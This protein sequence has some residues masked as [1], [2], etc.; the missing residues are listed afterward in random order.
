MR[1]AIGVVFVKELRDALRD[2]RTAL[3]IL[4]ASIITGPLT[5]VLLAQFVAGLEE[6]AAVLKVRMAGEE[7][8]PQL[9]NFL[10]RN[11]IDIEAAPADYEARVRE[12]RMDAVIVVP[13][14]FDERMLAGDSATVE[15][16]Y[17][18]SR[19]E[20]GPAIRQAERLLRAFSRE[21][22]TLRMVARGV[23][24]DLAEPVKVE[25]VNTATPRQKGALVLFLIPMFAILAPLLG[26]MTVAID[27]TAGERER[28]SLE[29][30]LAN[31]VRASRFAAGKWLAAWTLASVVAALTLSGFVVAALAYAQRKL[32]A[33]AAFGAFEL[34]QFFA[35]IV[36]FAAMTSALQLLICT[37]GRTYRE[38]Q[39][40]SSYVFTVVSFVPMIVLFSGLKDAFWQ[41]MVPVLGQQMVLARVMR[42]DALG[43]A[44]YLVPAAIAAAIAAACLAAVS[45][46]L[47][48]ERI[49]FGR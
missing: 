8:A 9:V 5:L 31:P 21:T 47:R 23:S 4:V 2:R 19:T 34:L 30:L 7:H 36:P 32:E 20:A 14:D 39:T 49:V 37:Y 17:D 22:G 28:G 46:L 18:D 10:R 41:L 48:Q 27:S 40:Y 35:M 24:P 33:L 42:G 44:D 15:I 38:A 26:G 16:V 1:G 29:P 3:M 25:R 13:D 45:H 6:K 12:G 43:L 11:D